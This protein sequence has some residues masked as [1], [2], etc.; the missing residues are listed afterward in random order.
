MPVTIHI[1][2]FI[3]I[4]KYV[5]R[6][7][8]SHNLALFNHYNTYN[9]LFHDNLPPNKTYNHSMDVNITSNKHSL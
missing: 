3:F 2:I 6:R 5:L 9:N 1:Y 7:I 4:S 8:S